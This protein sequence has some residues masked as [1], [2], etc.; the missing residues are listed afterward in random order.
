MNTWAWDCYQLKNS[1]V[2]LPFYNHFQQ[3]SIDLI[4]WD[5][6]WWGGVGVWLPY[7]YGTKA[8]RATAHHFHNYEHLN[9]ANAIYWNINSKPRPVSWCGWIIW[10]VDHIHSA[11]QN[12][13]R[14][15]S[16]ETKGFFV[17]NIKFALRF[18]A[19]FFFRWVSWN[20]KVN[21]SSEHICAIFL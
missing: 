13:H 1:S 2:V 18:L 21:A 4:A 8:I 14:N 15:W 5:M 9:V 6:H 12:K 10:C 16:C 20:S 7:I 3:F 19:H 11:L 17:I